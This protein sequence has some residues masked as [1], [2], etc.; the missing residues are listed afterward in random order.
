[1]LCV[2]CDDELPRL[3]RPFCDRCGEHFEGAIDGVFECPNCGKLKF[4]FRFARPAMLRDPRLRE[5]IHRLKYGRELH[6]A[7]ELGRL[8]REAFA[9]PRFETPLREKWPLVPVPL[10]RS[11][12][13]FRHF[14]QA[15]EIARPLAKLSGLPMI[16][17]LVRIRATT[18]Q[19]SLTRAQRLA[20]LRGAFAIGRVGR[21]LLDSPPPGVVLVDDVFTTG[22]TADACAKALAKAGIRDVVVVTVMRG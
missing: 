14:N 2:S 7:A 11:R 16:E 3:V 1:M 5:M 21:T 6:L 19:T 18:T 22:S 20:N 17:A 15:A 10:H 8:A 12:L 9:D 4:A 13:R